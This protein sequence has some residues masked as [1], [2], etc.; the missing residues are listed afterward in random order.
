M[1]K[2]VLAYHWITAPAGYSDL[3]RHRLSSNGVAK[4]HV[5]LGTVS[6]E[7]DDDGLRLSQGL[8]TR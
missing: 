2:L 5:V 8:E 3:S 4:Q 1:S 6:P 7:L